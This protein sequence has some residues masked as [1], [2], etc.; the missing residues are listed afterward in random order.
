MNYQN[1]F[2]FGNW[3]DWKWHVR[4]VSF[5]FFLFLN[6][7]EHLSICFRIICIFFCVNSLLI[8][9]FPYFY[10]LWHFFLF[11]CWRYIKALLK[12]IFYFFLWWVKN[13][14]FF[15]LR[16]TGPELTSMPIFLYFICGTPTTAWL[17]KRR[18]VCAWDSNWR[19][20]GCQSRMCTLNCCI[21]GPA[22]KIFSYYL[23]YFA[24]TV[25]CGVF[26]KED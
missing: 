17:A 7:S 25:I 15:I 9:L 10:W 16:K 14:F 8:I 2:I 26:F 6:E 3:I 20:L 22:Q 5:D 19:T 1:S 13:I 4:V 24:Y 21:T 11:L 23:I 12:P 18:H